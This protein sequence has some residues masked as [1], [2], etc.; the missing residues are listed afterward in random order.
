MEFKPG[1]T[2]LQPALATEWKASADGKTWTFKLRQGVTFQDGTP[3]NAEAVKFNIDRWWDANHPQGYRN[4]GKIYEIWSQVFGGFKGTPDSIVQSVTV[5][6]AA[7]VQI[8][9]KQPFAAFPN[10]IAAAWH[11]RFD[12]AICDGG[13]CG[14]GTDR[15]QAAVCRLS[16]RDRGGLFWHG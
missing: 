11:P 15:S 1:T 8:D 12:R 4:A 14:N 9:L 10:A 13:G 3:F 7:T 2:D 5:V 16:Q 6:D